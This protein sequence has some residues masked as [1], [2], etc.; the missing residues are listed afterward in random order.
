[1]AGKKDTVVVA[2]ISDLTTTQAAEIQKQIIIAKG[3]YAPNGRGTIATGSR[4]NVGALIQGN[5]STKR[6]AKNA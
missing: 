6:I 1:M 3:K 5:K 2:V 4:D